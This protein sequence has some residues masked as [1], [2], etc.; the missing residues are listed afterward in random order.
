[1]QGRYN[2][3]YMKAYK[4]LPGAKTLSKIMDISPEAK[5]RLKWLEWWAAHGRNTRLTCRH[6]GISPD[7]FYRWQKRFK[8]GYLRTLE[9]LSSKPKSLRQSS[10]SSLTIDLIVKLRKEDMGLSKYKIN[11][12]LKRDYGVVISS[13][14]IGRILFKRGL[15]KEANLIKSIKKK[16]RLNYIIPR[17]RASF[18][19]RYKFPGYLI[20]M[21]TKHLIIL[22]RKFY[23][24]LPPLI[25]ILN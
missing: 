10:I 13:S 21:D 14:T 3:C 16:K 11:Q 25:V 5:R 1:M 24:N 22:G 9:S 23:I 8:P 7:T 18:N 20:Q 4:I 15:I 17:I 12:I 6:F 19:L 2:G